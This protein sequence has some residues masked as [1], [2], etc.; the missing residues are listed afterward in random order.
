MK[1]ALALVDKIIK[2]NY[3]RPGDEEPSVAS[4]SLD[5]IL[6]TSGNLP[7]QIFRTA[8]QGGKSQARD[9]PHDTVYLGQFQI[10]ALSVDMKIRIN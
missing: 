10:S 1:Q 9:D 4:S 8:D 5:L 3:S 6:A 2:V 7:L